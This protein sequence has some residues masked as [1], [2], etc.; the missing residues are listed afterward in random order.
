MLSSVPFDGLQS[1]QLYTWS[2][3]HTDRT[4]CCTS[5]ASPC[6]CRSVA[7][8]SIDPA[9]FAYRTIQALWQA[10]MQMCRWSGARTQVLSFR[11]LSRPAAEDGL[12]A[13]GGLQA[14]FRASRQL[15]T[16]Q[17]DS[18][19][20]QRDQPRV[21]SSPR[22]ALRRHH[23]P[24]ASPA[25]YPARCGG[26]RRDSGQYVGRLARRNPEEFILFGGGR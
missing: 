7:P 20:D 15:S 23:E 26:W 21:A 25:S 17:R 18:G 6:P 14:G 24:A 13:S 11:E 16:N 10:W 5:E 3:A 22:S 9:W 8:A 1:D 4:R 19:G 12:C 2:D